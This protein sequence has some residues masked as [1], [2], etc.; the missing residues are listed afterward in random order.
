MLAFRSY[1]FCALLLLLRPGY[2]KAS[3]LIELVASSHSSFIHNVIEKVFRERQ[4][5]TLLYMNRRQNF[6][7]PSKEVTIDGLATL[8]LDEKTF[9]NV[10]GTFNNEVLCLVCMTEMT[11]VLLLHTLAQ[12]LEGMRGARIIILLQTKSSNLQDDFAIIGEQANNYNF[13]S[14]IVLHS[15]SFDDKEP[16]VAYRLQPFPSPSFATISNINNEQIFPKVGR[17]FKGKTALIL[18]D[19]LPIRSMMTINPRTGEKSLSG[20]SDRLIMEFAKKNNIK[21]RHL[22]AVGDSEYVEIV[23]VRRITS[24]GIL[25]LP[26]RSLIHPPNPGSNLE[27]VDV[28]IELTSIFIVVPCRHRIKIDDA[29]LGLRKYFKMLIGSYFIFNIYETLIKF[30]SNWILRRRPNNQYLNLVLNLRAFAGVLGFPMYLR[31]YRSRYSS[32]SLQ[33]IT[34]LLCICGLVFTS[35]F[36]ANLSTLMTKQPNDAKFK[37]FEQ[38]RKSG[39]DKSSTEC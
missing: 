29:F 17:D 23:D 3:P 20:F 38:L 14:L 9:I 36:N 5:E 31:R 16:I 10:K 22:K 7:C 8:R 6:N 34:M 15:T 11:D 25:D 12:N 37:T 26:I 30:G 33:Q 2:L 32:I 28:Q 27:Y 35:Y 4:V 1:T 19:L 18:P 24:E 39:L 21:L 13:V